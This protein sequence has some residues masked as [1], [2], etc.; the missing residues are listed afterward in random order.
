[1]IL[2]YI[3]EWENMKVCSCMSFHVQVIM[4]II[5]VIRSVFSDLPFNCNF[6]NEQPNN[7]NVA[8]KVRF[9]LG[10]LSFTIPLLPFLRFISFS[11]PRNIIQRD[12]L[13]L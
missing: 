1:M 11:K 6:H 9:A 2:F 4:F 8:C 3:F 7:V 10:L 13:I 12:L 5:I